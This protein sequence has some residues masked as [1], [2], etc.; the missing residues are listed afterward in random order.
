MTR[1]NAIYMTLSDNYSF[2]AANLIMSIRDNSPKVFDACDLILYHNGICEQN[3]KALRRIRD[4]I[5]FLPMSDD[6][7]K[8]TE[9]I[10]SNS[11]KNA[12]YGLEKLH[13]FDLLRDYERLLWFETDI[14]VSKPV[15]YLL[16]LE[17]DIAFWPYGEG[18]GQFFPTLLKKPSDNP[19]LCQ[20]GVTVLC[21]SIN[22][23]GLDH[24]TLKQRSDEFK[25]VIRGGEA[26]IEEKL[27][28]YLVYYYDMKYVT[29][30][31][32]YNATLYFL[33]KSHETKVFADARVQHFAA[34]KY[35]KPWE[36]DMIY[37]AFPK[38]AFNYFKFIEMGGVNYPVLDDKNSFFDDLFTL[39]T[40]VKFVKM[41]QGYQELVQDATK[42][43]QLAEILRTDPMTYLKNH[44][45]GLNKQG[46]AG[47]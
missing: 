42:Y 25:A 28:S 17:A 39:D 7:P 36:N 18:S 31:K 8:I 30:P 15:D 2:A 3:Q 20:G 40:L 10:Y 44:V 37:R 11:D 41:E 21:N 22:R 9:A 29:L 23:F 13:G 47:K 24:D 19:P 45:I 43:R 26:S 33:V 46:P 35:A 16:E 32:E 4:D 1:K 34:G 27:I 14:F 5:T 38:W 6:I 12:Q